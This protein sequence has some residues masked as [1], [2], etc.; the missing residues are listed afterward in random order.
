MRQVNSIRKEIDQWKKQLF[1][2]IIGQ[3][4]NLWLRLE[5]TF[6]S[7]NNHLRVMFDLIQNS[8]SSMSMKIILWYF[9]LAHLTITFKFV[10]IEYFS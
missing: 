9:I 7:S 6:S 2:M 5:V 4:E 3:S 1:S 10:S 8:S